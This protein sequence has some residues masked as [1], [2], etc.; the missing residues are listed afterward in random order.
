MV[1]RIRKGHYEQQETEFITTYLRKDIP[2]IDLGSGIGYTTCLIDNYVDNSVSVF[3][4]EANKGLIPV[5]K[6]NREL[7]SGNFRVI[8]SA[9]DSQN[10]TVDFQIAEDFWSS[11]QY[12]SPL[13]GF[14]ISS[15]LS[16]LSHYR[17]K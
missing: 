5:I 16:Q 14:K 10:D 2:T 17:S 11:S 4:I 7:N 8:H 3:G 12:D 9:Y 6:R 1:K 13:H 15:D